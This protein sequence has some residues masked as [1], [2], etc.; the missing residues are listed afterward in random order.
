MRGGLLI[1]IVGLISTL[2]SPQDKAR[3]TKVSGVNL[4]DRVLETKWR[5][6]KLTPNKRSSDEEFLRR[7]TLDLVG[8]IPRADEVVAF[9]ELDSSKKRDQLIDKL[10]ASPEW[11]DY[12][13]DRF[14]SILVGYR[15][16]RVEAIVPTKAFL[17]DQF[18]KNAPYNRIVEQLLTASGSNK[19][20]KST[21][22]MLFWLANDR[23]KKDLTVQVTKVFLGVQL[24]CAQCHDHPFEKW[25]KDDFFA[26]VANFGGTRSRVVQKADRPRD[27]EYELSDAPRNRGYR[28]EGYKVELKPKFIDGQP[29][30]EDNTRQEFARLITSPENLQFARATVNR[31]W[32]MFFGIGFVEPVDDFSIKNQPSLPELL[33]ELSRQFIENNYDLKWLMKTIVTSRAYQLSSRR[34]DK[35][36]TDESKKYFLYAVVRP[37]AAEQTLNV[38][39]RATGRDELP[40][41]PQGGAGS[42][43][44]D[45]ERQRRGFLQ[46]LVQT[47]GTE[48]ANSASEYNASIQQIMR[49]LDIDSNLY[50]G[51]RAKGGRG[52]QGAMAQILKAHKRPE[53]IITQ[54]YLRTVSR[55]PSR[56]E[57]Y[58]CVQYHSEHKGAPEAYEDI[59]FVLM[60]TN[61]FFF[62]H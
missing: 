31:V 58:R 49:M 39:Q 7:V 8:N 14:T 57:L 12:W 10:L 23:S 28:P 44:M 51:I 22:F 35:Q 11:S 53:E 38:L 5:E 20:E 46:Q 29:L 62:N 48:N 21:A 19:E 45:G 52:G 33:D 37:M 40:M 41:G 25:T 15:D 9:L 1:S 34:S 56:E 47:S 26:M 2:A 61:E 30:K 6:L 36:L 42:M 60:N 27:S 4:I 54:I 24:Q 16:P 13:S 17:R 59:F 32:S 18:R 50:R 55:Y 43:G 3:S